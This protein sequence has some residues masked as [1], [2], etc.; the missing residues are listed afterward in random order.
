MNLY[1]LLIFHTFIMASKYR[2]VNRKR[3]YPFRSSAWFPKPD[4]LGDRLGLG[5]NADLRN[6]NLDLPGTLLD[7]SSDRLYGL[8]LLDDSASDEV[9]EELLQ[10]SGLLNLLVEIRPKAGEGLS[11]LR[12]LDN[13]RREVTEGF[14]ILNEVRDYIAEVGVVS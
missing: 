12:A 8:L 9:T 1:L 7:L 5:F 3:R 4:S 14:V 11:G 2:N 6:G 10:T 13:T